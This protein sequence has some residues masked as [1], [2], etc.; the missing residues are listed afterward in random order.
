MRAADEKLDGGPSVL[1]DA[2]ALLP[3]RR[4]RDALLAKTPRPRDFVADAFAH[5]K[6]IGYAPAAA[7]AAARRPGL[8]ER[9]DDGFVELGGAGDVSTFCRAAASCASG[10]AR[11][12]W[13]R[14]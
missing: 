4:G 8:G 5:C 3:R 11:R 6:F 9:I 1:F 13:R 10:S 14:A 7:D 12:R 2:V